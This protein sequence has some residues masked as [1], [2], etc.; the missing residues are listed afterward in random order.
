MSK[1]RACLTILICGLFAISICGQQRDSQDPAN[2]AEEITRLEQE[3]SK[4]QVQGDVK[5]LNELLAP[6][7][8]EI[9]AAAQIRTEAENIE[10]HTSG[11][12]HWQ[13]FDL[14]DSKVQ[15]YGDTAVVTGRLTRKGTVAGRDLSGRSR[16]T[17]YYLKRQGHWQAIFQF[18]IP[19]AQ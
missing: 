12:V 19:D 14:T 16:Y 2:V 13:A 11:Q 18:S 7:F 9:N 1:W 8:I 6:E 4:A 17:R 3:R 5:R 10:G 15:V